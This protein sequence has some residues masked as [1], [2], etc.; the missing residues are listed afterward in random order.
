MKTV[1]ALF[2]FVCLLIGGYTV[3]SAAGVA[4]AP[5]PNTIWVSGP[6]SA[7]T[8]SAGWQCWGGSFAAGGTVVP[9]PVVVRF[10]SRPASAVTVVYGGCAAEGG[11]IS[12]AARDAWARAAY[13]DKVWKTPMIWGQALPT[14]TRTATAVPPTRTATRTATAAPP[15]ATRT[16][17]R[18][19][20]AI[21][22]ATP[23]P[24][25]RADVTHSS[26][27]FK[28]QLGWIV[29]CKA[30]GSST[31]VVMK[32]TTA[33]FYGVTASDCGA[34]TKPPY[35]SLAAISAFLTA[36]TGQSWTVK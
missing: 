8:P 9:G 25:L 4:P 29:W 30:Y 36:E 7:I 34:Q 22:T 10:N 32:V 14:A 3:A 18:T 2:M 1:A 17:T 26:G 24:M 27:V 16:S 23:L 6:S 33:P 28:P 11:S 31:N 20:T 12:L 19:A 21:P 15:T 35:S 5:T 13:P